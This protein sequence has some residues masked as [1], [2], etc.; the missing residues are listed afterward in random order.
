M[1]PTF[2]LLIIPGAVAVLAALT[3]GVDYLMWRYAMRKAKRAWL[4][5]RNLDRLRDV[6]SPTRQSNVRGLRGMR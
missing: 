5:Q 6:T 4:G 1:S 3:T 2:T